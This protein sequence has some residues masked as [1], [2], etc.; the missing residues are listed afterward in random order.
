MIKK[1]PQ[2]A[3]TRKNNSEWSACTKASQAFR[4]AIFPIRHLADYNI[5]GPINGIA[6]IAQKLDAEG[7]HGERGI[8]FSRF[9]ELFDGFNLN[10]TRVFDQVVKVPIDVL[11]DKKIKQLTVSIPAIWPSIQLDNGY[12]HPWCRFVVSLGLVSDIVYGSDNGCYVSAH[13][14]NACQSIVQNTEW[15]STKDVLAAETINLCIHPQEDVTENDVFVIGIGVEFGNQVVNGEVL[16]V[17]YSG[18][19]KVLR[20]ISNRD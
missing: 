14:K 4:M 11:F 15:K 9:K 18:S 8:F 5:S 10:K 17:K 7:V 1:A 19:A 2:F 20:L 13:E 6:K 3:G 12:N 16:P